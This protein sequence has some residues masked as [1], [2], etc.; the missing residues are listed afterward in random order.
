M[1]IKEVFSKEKKNLIETLQKK[2]FAGVKYEKSYIRGIVSN[3]TQVRILD[4]NS[5]L[6]HKR[7]KRISSRIKPARKFRK[8]VYSIRIAAL[9]KINKKKEFKGNSL[10]TTA[11]LYKNRKNH[12]L[13]FQLPLYTIAKSKKVL[14]TF[15]QGVER[16]S[17][18]PTIKGGCSLIFLSVGKGGYIC[19][20]SG[21]RGFLPRK[22]SKSIIRDWLTHLSDTDVTSSFVALRYFMKS[23]KSNFFTS[24]PS[25]Y[26]FVLKSLLDIV[27][28]KKKRFL[29]S[30]KKRLRFRT[31]VK[32]DMVFY[33]TQSFTEYKDKLK[34]FRLAQLRLKKKM[35]RNNDVKA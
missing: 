21:F 24:P 25:R 34:R 2:T 26:P 35:S 20:S 22:H 29:L 23:Q 15:V 27:S 1:F 19:Y 31:K 9:K 17:K 16:L 30:R 3:L 28:L 6:F 33:S 13:R 8:S 18:T 12:F 32:L 11:F 7:K 4:N 5:S 10:Y 14:D